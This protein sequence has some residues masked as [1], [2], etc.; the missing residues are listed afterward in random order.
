MKNITLILEEGEQ[1]LWSGKMNLKATLLKSIPWAV[2]LIILAL[3]INST[4]SGD[5]VS[6]TMNNVVKF[7]QECAQSTSL[8]YYVLLGIGILIPIITFVNYK[9][10]QYAVTE[11]RVVIKTGLIG[12]DIKSLYYDQIRDLSIQVGLVD[13]IF[14]T[15][16]IKIDTGKIMSG[17][18]GSQSVFDSLRNVDDAYNVYAI[19]QKVLSSRKENLYAGTVSKQHEEADN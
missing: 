4:L 10:T 5:S 12:A 13:K 14:K 2:T 17:K 8:M 3:F 11:K 19:A 6:C 15:G 9:V 7:G 18:N 1:I 16:S